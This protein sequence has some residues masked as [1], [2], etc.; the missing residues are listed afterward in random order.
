MG[1]R[2]KAVKKVSRRIKYTVA[3]VFKCLFCNHDKS[4]TCQLDTKSMA[5]YLSC[6]VCDAKFQAQINSLTEPI[7]IFTEWLD[8]TTE[9][10]AKAARNMLNKTNGDNGSGSG[11]QGVTSS[12]SRGVDFDEGDEDDWVVAK[13]KKDEVKCSSLN[14]VSLLFVFASSV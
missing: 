7:D 13:Q 11:S 10:Q 6:S 12:G 4:V 9:V 8:E 3:K 14:V 5:G 1:R 2:K